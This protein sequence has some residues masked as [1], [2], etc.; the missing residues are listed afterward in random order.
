MLHTRIPPLVG[1]SYASRSRI[2]SRQAHQAGTSRCAIRITRSSQLIRFALPMS[3]KVIRFELFSD[4]PKINTLKG[5]KS[6]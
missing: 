4:R 1:A 6:V 5:E 2:T 3:K